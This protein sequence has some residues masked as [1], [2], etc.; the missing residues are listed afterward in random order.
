[1]VR[2]WLILALLISLIFIVFL[3]KVIT[4]FNKYKKLKL[5]ESPDFKAKIYQSQ[6]P[7]NYVIMPIYID[8]KDSNPELISLKHT[9]NKIIKR[10]WYFM[11]LIIIAIIIGTLLGFIN[12]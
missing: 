9:Y 1:M 4:L 3:Y 11:G 6:L 7:G 12:E 8:E 5:I 10:W 2:Y